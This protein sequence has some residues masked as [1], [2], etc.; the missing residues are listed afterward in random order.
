MTARFQT[1]GDVEGVPDEVGGAATAP[2]HDVRTRCPRCGTWYWADDAHACPA[3]AAYIPSLV[4]DPADLPA[5]LEPTMPPLDAVMAH[6]AERIAAALA[7]TGT[8][9]LPTLLDHLAADA[10][11]DSGVTA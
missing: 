2:A 10:A 7:A 6:P 3:G 8:A 4:A 11:H 9:D 5:W 1:R